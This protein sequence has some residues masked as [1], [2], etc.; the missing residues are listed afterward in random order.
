MRI[1]M[2]FVLSHS[3]QRL[4]NR[5]TQKLCAAANELYPVAAFARRRSR[6]CW[7]TRLAGMR[8]SFEQV[9]EP[10]IGVAAIALLCS[11]TPCCDDEHT[12]GGHSPPGNQAQSRQHPFVET[13]R[14]CRIE[15]KLDRCCNFIDVLSTGATGADEDLLDLVR[16]DS[17]ALG[18]ADHSAL[19]MQC[20]TRPRWER[21]RLCVR[22]AGEQ[23][24]HLEVA[25][26]VK[27]LVIEP[28]SL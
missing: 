11:K 9:D 12:L 18:N 8:G 15:T 21:R 2:A 16:S 5:L 26:L 25:H 3:F 23:V 20:A 7:Y 1:L 10:F 22:C 24:R 14:A 27:I 28:D 13:G 4:L 19:P 17:D 6:A